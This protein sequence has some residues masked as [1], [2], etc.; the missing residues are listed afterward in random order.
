MFGQGVYLLHKL[1]HNG[2]E[3]VPTIGLNAPKG[4]RFVLHR[5][6]AI[7]QGRDLD[8]YPMPR[9]IA[10]AAQPLIVRARGPFCPLPRCQG[11]RRPG[12]LVRLAG[13]PSVTEGYSNGGLKVV[14]PF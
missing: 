5:F 13:A 3:I 10:P 11:S 4:L 6:S 2:V 12:S 14:E 8:P 7:A 9:V 1:K